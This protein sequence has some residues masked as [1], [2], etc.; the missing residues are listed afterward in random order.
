MHVRVHRQ[1]LVPHF[2]LGELYVHPASRKR[3]TKQNNLSKKS[4]I[5][6]LSALQTKGVAT[7]GAAPHQRRDADSG[8]GSKSAA[9]SSKRTKR[10]CWAHVSA[11]PSTRIW[12]NFFKKASASRILQACTTEEQHA[13]GME[14]EAWSGGSLFLAR[15]GRCVGW[16]HVSANAVQALV[17]PSTP[18]AAGNATG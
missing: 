11:T 15:P 13:A 16:A 2:D 18:A 3:R 14:M 5:T 17:G 12:N 4:R 6:I 10:N 7:L 8:V 1:V 9:T